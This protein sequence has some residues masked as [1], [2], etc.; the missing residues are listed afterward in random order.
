MSDGIN[1]KLQAQ[2]T[3][4]LRGPSNERENTMM[5]KTIRGET[6]VTESL[7]GMQA[8]ASYMSQGLANLLQQEIMLHTTAM[9]SK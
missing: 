5:K 4:Y 3:R 7:R 6:T 1:A 8:T 2:N 9:S